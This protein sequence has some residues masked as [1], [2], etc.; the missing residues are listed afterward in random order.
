MLAEITRKD[1]HA[2]VGRRA[3]RP[4][5]WRRFGA[6]AYKLILDGEAI[7]SKAAVGAAARRVLGREL[8]PHEFSGGIEHSAGLLVRLGFEVRLDG[9]RLTVEDLPR[10]MVMRPRGAPLRLYV[11]RPTGERTIAACH[12]HNFG[13]LLSPISTRKTATRIQTTDMSGHA[14]PVEGLPFVLD[15]GVWSCHEA[16]VEWIDEPLLRLVD[17]INHRD[18]KPEFVV[19]P[20]IIAAGDESL[21]FSLGWLKAKRSRCGDLPW[22]LAVQD[23]MQIE[24]VREALLEHRLAG[25]F[26][27]GSTEWKWATVHA[28]SE[29]ALALGLRVHVGRVNGQRRAKLCSDIGVHSIDGSMVSRFADKKAGLMA[30]S[31]DGLE[32]MHEPPGPFAI[33]QAIAERG[34]RMALGRDDLERLRRG[35]AAKASPIDAPDVEQLG[36][37]LDRE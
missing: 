3:R 31:C 15:N 12:A 17:R 35:K 28:W 11:C 7:D 14:T 9:E 19:A 22:L 24:R 33:R 34:L 25:I 18:L 10:R 1:G 20:D 5:A 13:A 36:L 2:A 8:R 26:V 27:G 6:G 29:L 16:A 4:R 23:G 37:G 30:K 32:L 21:A